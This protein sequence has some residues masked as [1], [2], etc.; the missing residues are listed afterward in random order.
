MKAE[1]TVSEDASR[2]WMTYV[3]I[4]G[5]LGLPSAKAGESKARRSNWQRQIA[6]DGL[7][8]V[9]VP[10]SALD[11]SPRFRRP[12]VG[13]TK[14]AITTNDALLTEALRRAAVAEGE[15]AALREA[16][17]HEREARQAAEGRADQAAADRRAAIALADQTVAL[18]TD[19]VAR[20]DQA[21][22]GREAARKRAHELANQ[23][24]AVQAAADRAEAEAD[25]LRRQAEAAQIAQAE[26]E[27][28]A[29]ELR[30]AE[31]TRKGRGVLAR[32]RG[33]WRGG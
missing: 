2:R 22:Q 6:N 11:S 19:A 21:E 31:A 18:L 5:A 17:R 24:M 32:L 28:D 9:A 3:E 7:A 13:P 27:A 1:G 25:E 12:H 33:A 8:R 30:Q 23:L 20:A 15:G 10:L 16:I 4:A 26:A 14:D 29:E